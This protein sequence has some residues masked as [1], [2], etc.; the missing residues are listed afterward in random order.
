M[1]SWHSSFPFCNWTGITCHDGSVTA[2]S[3]YNWNITGKIPPVICNLENLNHLDLAY[4]YVTGEFPTF[5]YNCS[6]LIYLDLSQNYFAGLIPGDIH[7]LSRLTYLNLGF[8][9]STT[10]PVTSRRQLDFYQT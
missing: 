1:N 3:F 2:I 4:N 6:K 5:L 7:R 10:S 8:K 9:P